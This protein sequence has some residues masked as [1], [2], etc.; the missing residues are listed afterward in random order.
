MSHVFCIH[1]LIDGHLGYFQLLAIRNKTTMNRI[2]AIRNK[3]TMNRIEHVPVLYGGVAFEY[4]PRSSIAGSSGSSIS[5]FLRNHQIDFQSDCSFCN[6]ISNRGVFLFL[7]I[8][9]RIC[10]HL[11]F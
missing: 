9:A 11:S 7:H 6:P 2:E 3:T 4:M 10:Y 5:N 1:S 8:L